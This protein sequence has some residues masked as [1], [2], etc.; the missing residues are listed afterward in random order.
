MGIVW[1]F[2]LFPLTHASSDLRKMKD[3]SCDHPRIISLV[4]IFRFAAVRAANELIVLAVCSVRAP[5]VVKIRGMNVPPS[6]L[7][8]R[9]LYSWSL[10]LCAFFSACLGV[11]FWWMGA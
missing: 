5:L 3:N 7:S 11:S 2:L 1:C 6:M 9:S 4:L 8:I 10:L